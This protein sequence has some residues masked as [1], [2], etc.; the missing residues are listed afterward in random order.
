MYLWRFKHFLKDACVYLRE[1][2]FLHLLKFDSGRHI[3]LFIYLIE[4]TRKATGVVYKDLLWIF[5]LRM[6]NTLIFK[7]N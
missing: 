4:P 6:Y 3:F 1:L 7:N 5:V 2:Y